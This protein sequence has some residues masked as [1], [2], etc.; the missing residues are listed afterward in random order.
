M[1]KRIKLVVYREHTLGYIRPEAP[2]TLCILYASVLRG[3]AFSLSKHSEFLFG[4]DWEF[5]RL[6]SENDF[7]SY[8][9]VWNGYDDPDK[10]EYA[11]F[12]PLS[13]TD[14]ACISRNYSFVCG[15]E[16]G[17]V[18]GKRFA[19]LIRETFDCE[20]GVNAYYAGIAEKYVRSVSRGSEGFVVSFY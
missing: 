3:A 19:E 12:P 9:L 15:G 1:G 14:R 2:N 20:E 11:M 18:S 6:A 10:Y 13:M 5:I 16:K 7:E 8:G 4:S 17:S